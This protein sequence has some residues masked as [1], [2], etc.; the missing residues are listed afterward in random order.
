MKVKNWT[1]A[2]T[3]EAVAGN[4]SPAE[5]LE[6]SQEKAPCTMEEAVKAYA[7]ELNLMF[8]ADYTPEDLEAIEGKLLQYIEKNTR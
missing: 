4:Q 1:P 7:Q 3:W 2:E 5:F 8:D 6:I